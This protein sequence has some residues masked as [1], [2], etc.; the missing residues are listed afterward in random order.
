MINARLV[1]SLS[2]ALLLILQVILTSCSNAKKENK[3]EITDKSAFKYEVV[4]EKVNDQDE[5]DVQ[6]FVVKKYINGKIE[7]KFKKIQCVASD[8]QGYTG[9]CNAITLPDGKLLL[10]DC[11]THNSVAYSCRLVRFNQD[12]TDDTTFNT[13]FTSSKADI[14]NGQPEHEIKNIRLVNVTANGIISM[15]G[16]FISPLVGWTRKQAQAEIGDDSGK[17]GI[18]NLSKDGAFISFASNQRTDFP[19]N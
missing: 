13:P 17:N 14:I 7:N 18:V 16:E 5:R 4:S 1:L 2:F 6:Y 9:K 19:H 12:G 10:S 15:E 3:L 11:F 8:I